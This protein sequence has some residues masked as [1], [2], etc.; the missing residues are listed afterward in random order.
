MDEKRLREI[1]KDLSA[2]AKG[3]WSVSDFAVEV[4]K[5]AVLEEHDACKTITRSLNI[6]PQDGARWEV[7]RTIERLIQERS[8]VKV[9]GA[10]KDAK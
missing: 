4:A 8:N 2:S 6:G 9:T 3:N 10:A 7:A 1:A 5:R